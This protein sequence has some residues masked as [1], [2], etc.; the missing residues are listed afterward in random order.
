[1]QTVSSPKESQHSSLIGKLLLS[2]IRF[3]NYYGLT[4]RPSHAC[5]FPWTCPLQCSY[6]QNLPPKSYLCVGGK[7]SLYEGGRRAKVTETYIL[8]IFYGLG[9]GGLSSGLETIVRAIEIIVRRTQKREKATFLI[10]LAIYLP[11]QSLLFKIYCP[12]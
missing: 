12:S 7:G 6:L 8:G 2:C 4:K 5:A 9:G 3:P 1:M 11:P 10:V